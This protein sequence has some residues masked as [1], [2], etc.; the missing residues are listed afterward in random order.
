MKYHKVKSSASCWF[1]VES[2]LAHYSQ[3]WRQMINV[4][5]EEDGSFT[6]SWDE[7]DPQES[8]L[9]TWTQEDFINA[10]QNKLE[11][12][13]E[14]GVADDATEAINQITENIIDQTEEYK[15]NVRKDEEDERLPRLF[16]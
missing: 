6:I 5:Q 10:I 11:S 16:F 15:I 4:E 14:L 3:K 12:L 7:N 8:I 13:E 1:V 2:F 9:N